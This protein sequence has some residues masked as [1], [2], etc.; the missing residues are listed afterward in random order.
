MP[1]RHLGIRG[2]TFLG[3]DLGSWI[4]AAVAILL[5]F[6]LATLID[7]A[8]QRR[9]HA[10][11]EAVLRGQLTPE[12]DTR[13]RFVRRLLYALIVLIGITAALSQFT[14]VSRLATSLLA[15]GA[16]AAAVIGFAARQILANVVAG[17]ILAVTQPI[18]VGDWVVFEGETGICEDVRLNYTVLRTPGDQRLIIPNEKLVTGILRNDTLGSPEVGLDVAV[19]IAP[20]ADVARAVAVL[21]QETGHGVSVAEAVPWGIRLAIGGDPSLPSERAGKEA[22]LRLRC[23][24]RLHAE[25]LAPTQADVQRQDPAHGAPKPPL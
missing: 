1:A 18:R 3:T 14:G 16:I 20:D 8:L 21:E 5:A 10:V 11:A 19:W 25:G 7:R 24:A 6:A 4:F 23:L 9:G 12:A 15:S 2:T 13:L 17:V 22:A